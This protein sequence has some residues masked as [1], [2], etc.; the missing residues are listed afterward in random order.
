MCCSGGCSTYTGSADIP[1]TSADDFSSSLVPPSEDPCLGTRASTTRTPALRLARRRGRGRRR[2]PPDGRPRRRQLRPDER[3][4]ARTISWTAAGADDA[5]LALDRN[6]NGRVDDGREL[7][8][9]SP[10][11]PRAPAGGG[12]QR[13]PRPRPLTTA[14]ATR[15]RGRRDRRRRYDLRLFAF[16]QDTNHNGV[17]EAT[18]L[19]SLPRSACARCT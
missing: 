14:R 3:R 15:Q 5:W 17:S 7:F 19:H 2:L 6:R 10:P 4:P 16:M 1:S 13:L 9:N 12:A 11:Q 8:G 18:E